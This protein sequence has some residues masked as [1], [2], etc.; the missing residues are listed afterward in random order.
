MH[1]W[2]SGMD[3]GDLIYQ[4]AQADLG[5]VEWAEGDNPRVLSYYREAGVPQ[6]HDEV[7]WCAAFVGAVLARCGLQGSGSLLARSYS[8]WGRA[9]TIEDARPGD[10]VVLARGKPWQGHVGFWDRR[11]GDKVYLLGGNQSNQVKRSAYPVSRIV[12][13][14]RAIAPEALPKRRGT[15]AESTTVQAAGL[16]IFTS[17]AAGFEALRAL[18]GMAQVIALGMA[19]LICLAAL[20]IARERVR[21]ILAG[22]G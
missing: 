22:L 2:G 11:E 6:P 12:A 7:P 21:K 13:V 4:T 9:V 8:R 10:V 3:L 15:P 14:R 5:V 18:D 19:G 20:W 16:Q 17:L 1:L